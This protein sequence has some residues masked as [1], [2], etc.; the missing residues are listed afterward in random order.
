MAEDV[1]SIGFI[2]ETASF[3]RNEIL[4]NIGIYGLE[5]ILDF[6]PLAPVAELA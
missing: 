1:R 6:F 3:E 4:Y 2:H 5:E